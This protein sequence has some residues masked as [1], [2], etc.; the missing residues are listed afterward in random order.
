LWTESRDNQSRIMVAKL[1]GSQPSTFVS[2]T[3][4]GSNST[5]TSLTV[6]YVEERYGQV[7]FDLL[8]S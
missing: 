3:I 7:T 5:F 2:V 4:N 8:L 1:D 6:D